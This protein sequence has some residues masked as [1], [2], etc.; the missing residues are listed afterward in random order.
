MT[1][2]VSEKYLCF[3]VIILKHQKQRIVPIKAHA[4][5]RGWLMGLIPF[6]IADTQ[7]FL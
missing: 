7:T 5:P 2:N 6:K 1:L 4:H 3:K